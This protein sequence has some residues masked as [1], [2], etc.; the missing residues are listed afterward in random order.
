[1]QKALTTDAMSAMCIT[2][3]HLNDGSTV[4]VSILF[5]SLQLPALSNGHDASSNDGIP[6]GGLSQAYVR[7]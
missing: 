3:E 4:K 1:M 5:T 6:K 2:S 7:A